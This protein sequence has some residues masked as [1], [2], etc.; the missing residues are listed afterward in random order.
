MWYQNASRCNVV[1]II[2]TSD[3]QQLSPNIETE[4]KPGVDS[5]NNFISAQ[6]SDNWATKTF[7]KRNWTEIVW[8][9]RTCSNLGLGSEFELFA[10]F[11]FYLNIDLRWGMGDV[12]G[13][14]RWKLPESGMNLLKPEWQENSRKFHLS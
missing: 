5:K 12:W 2:M 11:L 8:R 13:W 9:G 3:V 6:V 14:S 4:E 7:M 1:S 10:A